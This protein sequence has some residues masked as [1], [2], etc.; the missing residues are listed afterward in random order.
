LTIRNDKEVY[1]KS[2][3]S[4]RLVG[5]ESDI[6]IFKDCVDLSY[7]VVGNDI[8]FTGKVKKWGVYSVDIQ[9]IIKNTVLEK[10]DW[11]SSSYQKR[12][13]IYLDHNQ[14]PDALVNFPVLVN[15]TN[16]TWLALMDNSLSLR[17]VDTTNTTEYN[18]EIEEWTL[19]GMD[20]W[21]NV[22]SVSNVADTHFNMYFSNPIA[23]NGEHI[24]DTW[25]SNYLAVW[26]NSKDGPT[27]DSTIY[28]HD[29]SE[30]NTPEAY[31]VDGIIADSIDFEHNNDD[32]LVVASG[33]TEDLD[34]LDNITVESWF[35]LETNIRGGLLSKSLGSSEANT[36]WDLYYYEAG[37]SAQKFRFRISDGSDTQTTFSDVV[38]ADGDFHYV[39][40][41]WAENTNV[42]VCIDDGS[43][44]ASDTVQQTMNDVE[45]VLGVGTWIGDTSTFGWDGL[46]D[47]SRI[48]NIVRSDGWL[49]AIYN[50]IKNTSTFIQFGAIQ[51]Y[52][53]EVSPIY[54]TVLVGNET[55]CSCC[56]S[57][58]FNISGTGQ[59]NVTLNSNYTDVDSWLSVYSFDNIGNG[60]YCFVINNWTRYNYTYYFNY[61]F[62]DGLNFSDSSIYYVQTDLLSN[63]NY[64]KESDLMNIDINLANGLL[65]ILLVILLL[66]LSY[67]FLEKN[68]Y[69]SASLCA[70]NVFISLAVG[71]SY[72]G[73]SL[74]SIGW[75]IG[76]M[77]ILM[78]VLNSFL[79]FYY[80]TLKN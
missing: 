35:K 45:S 4:Y 25:D 72:I 71:I 17:F 73:N 51:T 46:I 57:L 62:D 77:M 39:V 50:N 53:G 48:S 54:F 14:I 40:G 34:N 31:Q 55:A 21:V 12:V 26:H 36:A 33:L 8:E 64:I 13:D 18:F 68:H 20:V 75:T 43:P 67:Y 23:T 66:Y 22:T 9:P 5:N 1:S 70:F 49:T 15:C 41:Y 7:K 29:M 74:F 11:W 30:I 61:S 80:G 78:A 19:T 44:V 52:S 42:Y 24:E 79:V 56:V 2:D 16:A 63:C 27:P 3:V 59:Y 38:T 10:Y 76:L 65:G 28:N 37:G 32:Y 6:K 60:T 58:C 47:E 69:L